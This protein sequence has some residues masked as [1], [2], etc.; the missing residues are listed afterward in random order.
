[1]W[2]RVKGPMGALI[3]TLVRYGWNPISPFKWFGG[4]IPWI[5][6]IGADPAQLLEV[7]R[8]DVEKHVWEQAARGRN[9]RGLENGGDVTIIRRELG[10]MR[11]FGRHREA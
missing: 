2:Q 11:K 10:R 1:M 3:A 9:G 6:Q 7:F 5:Y 8:V 4:G